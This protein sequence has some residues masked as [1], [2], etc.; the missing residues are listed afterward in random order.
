MNA[1][2]R[3]NI[4]R[5]CAKRKFFRGLETIIQTNIEKSEKGKNG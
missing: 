4:L 5:D 2:E 3:S 1:V